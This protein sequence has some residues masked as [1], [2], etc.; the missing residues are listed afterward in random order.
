MH[1]V[2][3]LL[4]VGISYSHHQG[5]LTRQITAQV[6]LS[7]TTSGLILRPP[8]TGFHTCTSYRRKPCSPSLLIIKP[9]KS[10]MHTA[11]R[12]I[13]RTNAIVKPPSV[14]LCTFH[15]LLLSSISLHCYTSKR[16]S[17][18]IRR[19]SD[20]PVV[21]PSYAKLSDRSTQIS[22]SSAKLWKCTGLCWSL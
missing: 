7:L 5:V 19:E 14:C 1:E 3:S 10:A 4:L 18:F 22:S 20:S 13:F 11:N 9:R 15:P 17:T 16:S 12:T 21:L 2:S 8:S 6:D